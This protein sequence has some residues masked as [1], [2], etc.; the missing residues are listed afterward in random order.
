M[1]PLLVY[2]DPPSAWLSGAFKRAGYPWRAVRDPASRE[3][4]RARGR[5]AGGCD[6][7]ARGP[8]LAFAA[9]PGG[10]P[11]GGQTRCSRCCSS[12]A[13]SCLA[14]LELREDLFDDFVLSDATSEEIEARLTH[15]FWRTGRGK[16][17]D[18]S[19]TGPCAQPGDLPGGDPGGRST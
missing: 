19:S 11:Q 6:I 5:F 3:R 16:S 17:L 12:S 14:E 18:L 9:L 7:G 10:P 4:G 15:L 13:Q 8:G 1:E 2:P